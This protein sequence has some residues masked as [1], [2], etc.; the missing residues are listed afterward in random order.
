M[1]DGAVIFPTF[2]VGFSAQIDR[3]SSGWLG[4]N[5]VILAF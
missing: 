2:S 5:K 4:T 1:T 3:A